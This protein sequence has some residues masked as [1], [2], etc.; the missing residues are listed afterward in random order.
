MLKIQ[1]DWSDEES[2][3]WEEKSRSKS[4]DKSRHTTDHA[5]L[6][7]LQ[8]LDQAVS[9]KVE[10]LEKMGE[11]VFKTDK[12]LKQFEQELHMWEWKL[13]MEWE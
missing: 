6:E 5:Q 1:A 10:I 11:R 2:T 7:K 4:K 13:D 12:R 3:R 9:K 8:K